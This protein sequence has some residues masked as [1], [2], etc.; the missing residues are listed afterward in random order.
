MM[1]ESFN[2]LGAHWWYRWRKFT[3]L[4]RVGFT[5]EWVREMHC[6]ICGWYLTDGLVKE[7][8]CTICGWYF[9]DELVKEM[10]CAICG[11]YFTDGL[12]KEMHCTIC[13]WYFADGLVK[14]LHCTICGWYF[15]DGLVKEMHCTICGWYKYICIYT[16]MLTIRKCKWIVIERYWKLQGQVLPMV[17]KIRMVQCICD[18]FN[19]LFSSSAAP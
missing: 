3:Y 2:S 10:H 14:E 18:I 12:V 9:T 16:W 6:T 17:W 1:K 7:M 5:D 15:T 8:H 19:S 13:V 4:T 11:W